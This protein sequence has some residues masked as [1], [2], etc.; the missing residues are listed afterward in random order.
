MHHRGTR[1]TTEI[2]R[3]FRAPP[4][5]EAHHRNCTSLPCT[6]AARPATR[7]PTSDAQ[8]F[9]GSNQLGPQIYWS[10]QCQQLITGV[11]GRSCAGRRGA[12]GRETHTDTARTAVHGAL[13]WTPVLVWLHVHPRRK[14]RW[15]MVQKNT[16]KQKNKKVPQNGGEDQKPVQAT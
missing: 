9:E 3:V 15:W 7:Q 13:H 6:T 4:R 10:L 11:L 12:A 8:R 1:P 16:E 2:A 14:R 5:H